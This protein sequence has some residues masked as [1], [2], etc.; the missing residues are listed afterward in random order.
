MNPVWNLKKI[1]FNIEGY[2]ELFS[3]ITPLTG[4]CKCTIDLF[5]CN[6][7]FC[8]DNLCHNE[9]KWMDW[10]VKTVLIAKLYCSGP[11]WLGCAHWGEGGDSILPWQSDFFGK[12]LKNTVQSQV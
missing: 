12:L 7:E 11:V 6:F 5:K 8:S 4:I 9:W 3:G 1:L 10:E 2:G